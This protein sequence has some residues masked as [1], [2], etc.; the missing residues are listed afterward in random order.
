MIGEKTMKKT[1]LMALLTVGI[2]SLTAFT[3]CEMP[4]GKTP[5]ETTPDS[6]NGE[7]IEI[8]VEKERIAHA[9][10]MS[11]EV[12][13]IDLGDINDVNNPY[14]LWDVIGWYGAI[15]NPENPAMTENEAFE[16]QKVITGGDFVAIEDYYCEENEV[17][18]SESNGEITYTFNE[19]KDY[20]ET[21]FGMY[22]SYESRMND[23]GSIVITLT[24]HLDDAE[25]V[26]EYTFDF[27]ESDMDN[28]VHNYYLS[29]IGFNDLTEMYE[30]A[31]TIAP[32]TVEDLINANN[33]GNLIDR[34]GS[35]Q[36]INSST[37]GEYITT[38]YLRKDSYATVWHE[39]YEDDTESYGGWYR[40]ITYSTDGEGK[41]RAY[42]DL[43]NYYDQF[44]NPFNGTEYMFDYGTP[45]ILEETDDEYKFE[46]IS[47]YSFKGATPA[48][49]T[50]KKEDLRLVFIDYKNDSACLNV[51]YDNVEVDEHG[52][53][54]CWDKNE[55]RT[56]TYIELEE[57]YPIGEKKSVATISV[58]ENWNL[59]V[60]EYYGYEYADENCSAPFE[61]PGDYSGDYT[62]YVSYAVG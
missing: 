35:Y 59:Q 13:D 7:T 44:S 41:I 15:R 4:E 5:A 8:D 23:E 62:V 22:Y 57:Y 20:F 43:E 24:D 49:Y 32:F 60:N 26:H 58:P 33:P 17:T 31:G 1:K 55:L 6:T 27:T 29:A 30:S 3:A 18:K 56:V 16:I 37:Y 34:F 14:Y 19:Q 40:G 12:Y 50:V 51:I 61:Y 2:L 36:T 21:I 11:M 53:F 54:D 47:E 39:T 28:G 48:V 42:I 10:S 9:V 25:I 52:A 45:Y 38:Y 46:I